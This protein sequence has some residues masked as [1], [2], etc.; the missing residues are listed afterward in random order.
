MCKQAWG[1]LRHLVHRQ[2]A[3][4]DAAEVAH[5]QRMRKLRMQ[6]SSRGAGPRCSVPNLLL[7]PPFRLGTTADPSF[8]FPPPV[9]KTTL[10]PSSAPRLRRFTSRATVFR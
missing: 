1:A 4:M 7:L 2:V 6:L 5:E 10:S 3:D 9:H 8:P